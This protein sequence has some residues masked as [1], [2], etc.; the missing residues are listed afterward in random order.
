VDLEDLRN[1]VAVARE[2]SFTRAATTVA[3][4]Q[5]ALSRQVQRLERTL[6]VQLLARRGARVELTAAGARFLTFAEDTLDRYQTLLSDLTGTVPEVAGELRIV[7]STTPGEFV[8]PGLVSTFAARYPRVHALVRIADT[9]EVVAALADGSADLGF[10]GAVIERPGL[11][12]RVIGEDEIVLAV[13]AAHPLAA[14]GET[15]VAALA[16]AAFVEREGG[17]GTLLM[18]RRLLAAQGASLPPHRVVMSLS[19]TQAIVTAVQ[20]GLGVGFVSIQA[21]ERRPSP[22]VAIVRLAGLR[23]CRPLYLVVDDRQPL[24]PVA[25]AFR[26][27]VVSA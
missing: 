13:P 12:Y 19:T 17:S 21:L 2:G 10:T 25:R 8:V 27:L 6:G 22:G 9:A 5:P 23:L 3:L 18:V 4:T 15:L 26:E 7:A 1:F 14:S 16:G 24:S 20:Q 11:A